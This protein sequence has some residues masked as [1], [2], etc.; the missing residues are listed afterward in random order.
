[1][2]TMPCDHYPVITIYR[3]Y[4]YLFMIYS[5]SSLDLQLDL[6]QPAKTHSKD[7][8]S[9]EETHHVE[10]EQ[11]KIKHDEGIQILQADIKKLQEELGQLEEET[12]SPLAPPPPPP[13][14]VPVPPPSPLLG[15]KK[16]RKPKVAMKPLFWSKA[17]IERNEKKRK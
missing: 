10:I 5:S 12:S 14:G 6:L 13:G 15:A 9:R 17:M 8:E 7:M 11:L 4:I 3:I 1:M 16:G 2:I